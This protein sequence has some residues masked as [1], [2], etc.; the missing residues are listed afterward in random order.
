MS[1]PEANQKAVVASSE[2]GAGSE[3]AT[4]PSAPKNKRSKKAEALQVDTGTPEIALVIN[5]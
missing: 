5:T 2:I 3:V 1:R 4:K